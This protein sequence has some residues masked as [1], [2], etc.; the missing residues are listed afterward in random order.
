MRTL[1]L[2]F[3]FYK[4]YAYVSLLITLCCLMVS[5]THG[6]KTFTALFW[7]KIITLGLILFFINSYKGDEY[8]Y[9]KN[10]GLHKRVLW[11]STLSFDIL[12]FIILFVISIKIR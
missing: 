12:V 7:F 6:I 11:I 2:A 3:T 10:L 4:S 8:Y 9:Y 5:Y 1:R